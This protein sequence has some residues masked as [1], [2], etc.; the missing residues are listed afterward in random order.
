MVIVVLFMGVVSGAPAN[1]EAILFSTFGPGNSFD[2]E[3]ASFFGFD[4][5]S[6]RS[7]HFSR[8]MPLVP[9]STATLRTIDLALQFPFVFSAGT[10]V[11]NL[12][13]DDG[14]LPGQVLE[15][16]TRTQPHGP[17]VLSLRSAA[18]PVLESGRTY[19]VEATTN[20]VA[21]GLW[22]HSTETLFPSVDVFRIDHGPW[23][24]GRRA[25]TAAFRIIGD[26]AP[27][28]EPTTVLLL[29]GAVI[30]GAVRVRGRMRPPRG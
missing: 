23:Q 3:V 27:I 11:V 29:G 10:L 25:F 2:E 6:E 13:A 4:D 9:S 17:G 16:F 7:F 14:G 20:G 12:F 19:F 24:T 26:P 8:A 30:V 22:F 21:D 28:P 15:T 18:Q 1:A 5:G